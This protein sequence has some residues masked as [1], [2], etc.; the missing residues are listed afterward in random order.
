MNF[1]KKRGKSAALNFYIP[2]FSGKH[3]FQK[4]ISQKKGV[5]SVKN[6]WLTEKSSN[7]YL[8]LHPKVKRISFFGHLF[9]S[10]FVYPRQNHE[11][12]NK[13]RGFLGF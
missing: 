12:K 8:F 2:P 1:L 3:I 10:I 4:K 6:G 9:L 5:K 13:Y 7:F 11:K